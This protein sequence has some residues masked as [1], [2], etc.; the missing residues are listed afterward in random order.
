MSLNW[1]FLRLRFET[2]T[3]LQMIAESVGSSDE[4]IKFQTSEHHAV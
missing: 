4:V 2:K 3:G 1:I